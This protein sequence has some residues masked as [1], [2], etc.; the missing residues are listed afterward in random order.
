MKRRKQGKEYNEI[1]KYESVNKRRKITEEK[2][3][4]DGKMQAANV[5]RRV[6]HQQAA[7]SFSFLFWHFQV[8]TGTNVDVWMCV[9]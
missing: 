5:L 6:S 3:K 2:Q 4:Q 9:Y 7:F 1:N 8:G